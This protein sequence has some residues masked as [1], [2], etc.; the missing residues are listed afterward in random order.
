[1]FPDVVFYSCCFKKSFLFLSRLFWFR[2]AWFCLQVNLDDL[3]SPLRF[4]S[5]RQSGLT[6]LREDDEPE[7]ARQQQPPRITRLQPMEI[8]AFR[9]EID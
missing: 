2:V 6:L 5:V 1:M 4:R 7:S 8:T 3:F 9:V